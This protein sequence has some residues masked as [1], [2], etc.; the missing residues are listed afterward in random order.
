MAAAIWYLSNR[1][2][3]LSDK[4]ERTIELT[5]ANDPGAE[6][7]Q[8]IFVLHWEFAA[9]IG[10]VTAYM[11]GKVCNDSAKCDP[12]PHTQPLFWRR[13]SATFCDATV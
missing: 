1:D 8:R 10:G 2:K 5:A 13:L 11:V 3:R 7:A 12:S 4:L 6:M 9:M